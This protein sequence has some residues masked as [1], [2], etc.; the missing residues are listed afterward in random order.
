MS[1]EEQQ[2]PQ[3]EEQAN[4]EE[5]KQEQPEEVQESNPENQEEANQN[6][7]VQNQGGEAE[8]EVVAEPQEEKVYAP[9]NPTLKECIQINQILPIYNLDKNIDAISTLVYENDDLLN[10]FLQKV[11]TRI[12]VCE[13]DPKG[14]FLKCE[15]NR[16]GESYRSPW[17]NQYFPETEDAKYPSAKLRELE[18][19][20]NKAFRSYARLYY[21]SSAKSSVYCWELG[22]DIKEGFGAAILIKNKVDKSGNVTEG[23]WDSSNII[24]VSF[25]DEGNK[26]K[27]TYTLI[28]NVNLVM[29]LQNKICGKI[30]LSGTMA[31]TSHLT[32]I[33]KDYYSAEDHVANMGVM[34][35][36][37][38]TNIRS[39]LEGTYIQK[40]EII[41]GT[42]R[43]GVVG[44][45]KLKASAKVKD[46]MFTGAN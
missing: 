34:V 9:P 42:A 41:L 2:Q 46:L 5:Q 30:S 32:K 19:V 36:N 44:K 40:T 22:E 6:L 18:E 24:N 26:K 15:Q 7:E 12:N 43:Y 8:Q 37:M 4:E 39:L 29:G 33:I 28:C 23:S 20:L 21:G 25:E 17:S 31:K 16:D 1:E 13:D 10:E 11:D 27:A 45:N 38:E 3:Y 14:E 35:E